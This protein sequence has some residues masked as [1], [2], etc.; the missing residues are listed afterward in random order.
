MLMF[1]D[2]IKAQAQTLKLRQQIYIP[3]TKQAIAYTSSG[4]MQAIMVQSYAFHHRCSVDM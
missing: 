1:E 3:P 4:S 2:K